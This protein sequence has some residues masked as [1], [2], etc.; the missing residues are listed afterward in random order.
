MRL[1]GV[2]PVLVALALLSA[3]CTNDNS[4]TVAPGSP[5]P[6]PDETD[7]STVGGTEPPGPFGADDEVLRIATSEPS[8]LDPMRIG[9]PGSVLV[10]RQLFEGL[11]RWDPIEEKVVPAVAERWSSSGGGREFTFEL[12]PG[13]TFHDGSPVTSQDFR[14]AFD[15]I[16]QKRNA[17]DLAYTL[18]QVEGFVEVNELGDA[19]RL[20]GISTP[21]EL[22][23]VIRLTEPFQDLPSVLTHPG[24][25]PVPQS[26][27]ADY[28]RFLSEPVGNGPLQIAEPW[29]GGEVMLEDFPGFIDTPEIDGLRVMPFP[30]AAASWIPFLQGDIDIAEVPAGQLEAAAEE[31]GDDGFHPFLAGY[32]YGL[33]VDSKQVNNLRV[34]RAISFAIDREAIAE[35]IYKGTLQPARGIVPVG[36]PGFFENVCVGTCDYE[37]ERA[38]RI[39]DRLPPRAR[40]VTLAFNQG[41]PHREVARA[42]RRDLRAAGLRVRLKSYRFSRYLKLLREGTQSAYRLGWI[43]EYPSPDV[44]LW[45]LF[46]SSSPDN[47]SGF[48]S[49]RVDRVL[50]N[51]RA[52]ASENKR[53]Q[54]Y[55]RAEKL[56][57]ESLPVV[58]VGSFVTHWA[59]QNNVVDL[60]FDIMG[61]F[62]AID[63]SLSEDGG[64]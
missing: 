13:T 63:V 45:S 15:R 25:V 53:T 36:M 42:I 1:G 52:E 58:P 18:E 7:S 8:T 46:H 20:R 61:G 26:A 29:T 23:L 39:V 37:P 22:T 4:G 48:E 28:N 54:L 24:L 11:T 34:R 16:A 12:R 17:S 47:H 33:N 50:E 49:K 2:V 6:S 62:D 3:A 56:I 35:N 27:V 31:F 64:G 57:L 30:D 9:D 38:K 5:S 14:F 55:I 10:A 21:D 51:A 59:A 41:S 43:S 32:Y 60:T 19:S 40:R 44:F